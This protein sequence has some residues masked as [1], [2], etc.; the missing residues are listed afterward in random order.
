MNTNS[1]KTLWERYEAV[2]HIFDYGDG[3][4]ST[5]FHNAGWNI[6]SHDTQLARVE[7]DKIYGSEWLAEAIISKLEKDAIIFKFAKA[8]SESRQIDPVIA[9][10]DADS[11]Y[12]QVSNNASQD[13]I[14]ELMTHVLSLGKK[15]AKENGFEYESFKNGHTIIVETESLKGDWNID[16]VS[17]G[18]DKFFYSSPVDFAQ[19]CELLGFGKL[20]SKGTI[21]QRGAS[22]TLAIS[23]KEIRDVWAFVIG[24]SA[25]EAENKGFQYAEIRVSPEHSKFELQVSSLSTSMKDWILKLHYEDDVYSIEPEFYPKALSKL[26]E[27]ARQERQI[28]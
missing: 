18:T 17:I 27:Y 14:R 15:D 24:C 2:G 22:D 12:I 19:T 5:L 21:S 13:Q 6:L 11:S 1:T 28:R 10:R 26:L 7:R 8:L 16:L 25:E 23:Q 9:Y 3:S 4:I 20:N